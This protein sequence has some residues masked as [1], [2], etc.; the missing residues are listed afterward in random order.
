MSWNTL[1][2]IALMIS[3]FAAIIFLLACLY[4]ETYFSWP[5]LLFFFI[6]P[7]LIIYYYIL[8]IEFLEIEVPFSTIIKNTRAKFPGFRF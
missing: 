7:L 1:G 3:L 8:P 2:K 6:L 4:S 5:L